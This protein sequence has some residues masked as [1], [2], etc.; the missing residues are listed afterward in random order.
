V[1]QID[2]PPLRERQADVPLLVSEFINEFCLREKR[3][4][5]LSED[6]MDIFMSYQ[7]P[8]NIRQLRNV[9]ER[10]IVLTKGRTISKNDLPLELLSYQRTMTAVTEIKPLKQLELQAINY[11]LQECSGNKSEAAKKL[12]ISRKTFYKRLKEV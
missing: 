5:T 8:G 4:L 9:I 3:A 6:V 2:V 1:I 12:G 10:A 7:W 11:A